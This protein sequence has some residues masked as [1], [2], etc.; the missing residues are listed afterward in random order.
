MEGAVHSISIQT[1]K[2]TEK[3]RAVCVCVCC[4][5]SPSPFPPPPPPPQIKS[6]TTWALKPPRRPYPCHPTARRMPS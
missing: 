3:G 5:L 1:K 6:K 2:W 4:F